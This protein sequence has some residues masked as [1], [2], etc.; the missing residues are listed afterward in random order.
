MFRHL[1]RLIF[2]LIDWRVEDHRPADLGSCI[3]VVAPHTSNWDFVIGVFARSIAHLGHV[4]YLA[5]SNFRNIPGFSIAITPE[6]TRKRV[7][8]WRTGFYHIAHQAGVPVVL[9]AFDYPTRR[10]IFRE[11]FTTT[12]DKDRDIAFMLDWFRRFKG[13]HPENGVI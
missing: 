10:V 4:K 3:Y 9:T 5:K 6:G 1:A 7:D 11:P 13:R 12:G 2:R 8:R